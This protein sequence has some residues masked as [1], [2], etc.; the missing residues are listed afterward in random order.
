M[1]RLLISGG[2]RLFIPGGCVQRIPAPVR[3]D[4]TRRCHEIELAPTV[5]GR[6]ELLLGVNGVSVHGE[7]EP[8]ETASRAI[9]GI[10]I[11]VRIY[12]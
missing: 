6:L 1:V 8:N 3:W 11:C 2:D 12:V 9:Y 4:E 5:A 7:G 10:D